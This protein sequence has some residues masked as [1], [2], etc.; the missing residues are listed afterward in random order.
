MR[1]GTLLGFDFGERRIGVAVGE[2]ETGLAHPVA[3][4]AEPAT[5]ARLA[6]IEHSASPVRATVSLS[7]G[8]AACVADARQSASQLVEQADRALYQA[9][10]AGRARLVCS[11]RAA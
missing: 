8:V 9:K 10:Q 6:A 3:T 7:I 5:A 4:I 2:M 11:E 1:A